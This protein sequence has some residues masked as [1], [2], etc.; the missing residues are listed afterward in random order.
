MNRSRLA[1]VIVSALAMCFVVLAAAEK[2]IDVKTIMAQPK[3]YV[4]S[5]TAKCA[6]SNTLT[7]GK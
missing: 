6:T 5:E 4:G 1:I 3:L 7:P 2:P